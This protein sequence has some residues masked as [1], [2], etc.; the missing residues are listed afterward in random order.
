ML[1]IDFFFKFK[2]YGNLIHKQIK[3]N[4]KIRKWNIVDY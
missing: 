1:P 4:H 2:K 3:T